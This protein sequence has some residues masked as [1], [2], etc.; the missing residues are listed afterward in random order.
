[1][2]LEQIWI[3]VKL[4]P[5]Q[6]CLLFISNIAPNREKKKKE[7]VI[8]VEGHEP[9]QYKADTSHQMSQLHDPFHLHLS[10]C[11]QSSRSL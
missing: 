5:V 4:G 1:M 9:A 11:Q 10:L 8:E 2:T 6:N 7:V 3:M